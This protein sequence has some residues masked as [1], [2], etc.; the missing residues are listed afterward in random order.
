MTKEKRFKTRFDTPAEVVVLCTEEERMT[1]SEFAD[2]CD[3]NAIMD[4]YQKKRE[5]P[6]SA[7]SA[8]ARFGDFSQVPT[9]AEMQEKI[10]AANEMF[11]SLPATVRKLFDN[12]PGEFV[13]AADSDE[14]RKYLVKLGLGND[15]VLDSP[16]SP[17]SGSL[18]PDGQSE[19]AGTEPAPEGAKPSSTTKKVK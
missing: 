15:S 3:I 14:G 4:R 7:R 2:E 12:D 6:E 10:I 18:S 16:E 19:G 1:K 8:A 9:F 11:M 5:L 13:A 17:R